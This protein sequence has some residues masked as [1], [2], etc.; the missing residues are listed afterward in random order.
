MVRIVSYLVGIG[1]VG[2]L[3]LSFVFGLSAYL[4]EEP[5][6]SVEYAFHEH[7]RD[8]SLPSNGPLG[9]FDRA[10][11]Q[12]GFKVF[13]EVC[14]ACHSLRYV[15]FRDLE[16]LGYSEAEVRAIAQNWP[17][18]QPDINADTG[19]AEGRPNIPA[20]RF[21]RPFAN[22]VAARAANNNA[23]PP[24][25]SLMTKARHDGA[26]YVYSLLSGYADPETYRNHD[27]EALPA[28]NR[29]GPGLHFNPYFPN[30]NLAM[31]PPITSDGQVT[32]DDGTPSTVDSMS[33]DVAAFLVWTAE[34]KLESR[35]A[36]GLGTILF[37]V[38]FT[39]LAWMAYRNIWSGVK[40]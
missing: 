38:I 1:F 5:V 28:D 9:R 19:E 26:A 4:S 23:V 3:L 18:Q 36:A 34:P 39:V 24:D 10:Q 40:H 30:L 16:Q 20:D 22:D 6:E 35:H 8:L 32:F 21:P 11:L 13:Q 27:G 31:A 14:A 33:R 15:A 37:L 17:I 25:L 2:A 7:P 12:R 29:P